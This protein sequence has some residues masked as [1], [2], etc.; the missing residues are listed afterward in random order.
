[1]TG[2][3]MTTLIVSYGKLDVVVEGSRLQAFSIHDSPYFEW[4]QVYIFSGDVKVDILPFIEA[5]GESAL[6]R[7][8]DHV[9]DKAF[10]SDTL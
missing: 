5:L 3:K 2:F 8:D 6:Q 10:D 7:F 4:E 1:M 9:Q